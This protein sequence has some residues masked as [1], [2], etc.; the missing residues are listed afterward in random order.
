MQA[1]VE[2]VRE[3]NILTEGLLSTMFVYTHLFWL[4]AQA[5]VE[6]VREEVRLVVFETVRNQVD[7]EMRLLITNLKEVLLLKK[8]VKGLK[9]PK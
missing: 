8:F 5:E 9:G 6:L 1:E 4:K 3:I 7:A 2:L